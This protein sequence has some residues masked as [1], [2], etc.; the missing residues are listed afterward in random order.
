VKIDNNILLDQFMI[1]RPFKI[2]V[3]PLK[4]IYDFKKIIMNAFSNVNPSITKTSYF[5]IWRLEEKYNINNLRDFIK[6]KKPIILQEKS[7][8]FPGFLFDC[9]KFPMKN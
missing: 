3:S 4:T 9:K 8:I 7:I 2:Y 5:R 1:N 6:S